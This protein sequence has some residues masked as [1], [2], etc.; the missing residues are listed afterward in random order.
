MDV[1]PLAA[2]SL[3]IRGLAVGIDT[4]DVRV[5]IDPSC[6]LANRRFGLPPSA[7]EHAALVD[8]RAR[9]TAYGD[10][11][12]V[13]V[14][15]HYHW[16]H[17]SLDLEFYR[18]KLILAKSWQEATSPLCAA[19]GQT[20]EGRWRQTSAIVYADGAEFRFGETTV[21]VSPP[22]PHGPAGSRLGYVIATVVERGGVKVLHS[23]DTQGPMSD[24]ATEW[25]LAESPDLLV[26]DGPPAYLAGGRVPQE[27]VEIAAANLVRIARET[28]ATILMDHHVF[29]G[30]DAALALPELFRRAEPV[31]FA[32]YLGEPNRFLEANRRALSAPEPDVAEVAG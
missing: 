7:A 30:A 25:F 12:D 16:D 14:V 1:T 23:S 6:A 26:V 10:A 27:D 5:L 8:A 20:F 21:R 9:L 11:A 2:E 18:E 13:L 28:G 3:G 22:L 19:R 31:S 32:E 4:P 24:V 29:R 17:V 15:S